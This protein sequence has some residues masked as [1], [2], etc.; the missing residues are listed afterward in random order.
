MDVEIT[1][2][3]MLGLA[4]RHGAQRGAAEKSHFD[5]AGEDVK[6]QEPALALDAVEWRV[7][8]DRLADA[9]DGAFDS[10]VE[11]ASDVAFPARH[12]R[13]IGPHGC[14]AVTLCDLGVAA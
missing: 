1:Y 5:V 4:R 12:G 14:V 11:T 9:G 10:C 13:D 8:F 6:R 3:L 2:V 7:P